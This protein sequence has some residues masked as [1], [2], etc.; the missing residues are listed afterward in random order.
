MRD[1]QNYR[2]YQRKWAARRRSAWIT[3]NGPCVKCGSWDDLE[4]DHI[5]RASKSIEPRALWSMSPRNPLRIAELPKL[6]VLCFECHKEKSRLEAT[7]PL[8]H[9][10]DNGYRK[11]RC[12]C[13]PCRA[14]KRADG[15]AWKARRSA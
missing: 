14:W 5:D 3:A 9:G 8:I 13:E 10:T 2:E 6:Q 1:L 15:L 4:A 11:K 12:R 7:K